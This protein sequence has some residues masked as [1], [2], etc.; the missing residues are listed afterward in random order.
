MRPCG[1]EDG[2]GP[3]TRPARPQ[4][5]HGRERHLYKDDGRVNHRLGRSPSLGTSV[6]PSFADPYA[7]QRH[8]SIVE[9]ARVTTVGDRHDG[10]AR[11]G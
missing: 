3:P 7:I 4:R 10:L 11:T 9:Y 8:R 1:S 2:L 5:G 6:I